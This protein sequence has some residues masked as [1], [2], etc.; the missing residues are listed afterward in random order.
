M[1]WFSAAKLFISGHKILLIAIAAAAVLATVT[2]YVH[3]A[4]KAKARN[5]ELESRVQRT[6]QTARLNQAAVEQCLAANEANAL[7]ALAQK[8]RARDAELRLATAEANAKRDINDINRE[9]DNF[10]SR[11]RDLACPALDTDFREWVFQSAP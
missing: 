1:G 11:S 8:D 5:T 9:A 2:I 7:A 10:R 4:E 6:E 3:G